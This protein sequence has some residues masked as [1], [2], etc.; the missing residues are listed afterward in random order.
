MDLAS[1]QKHLADV[2]FTRPW[3]GAILYNTL[4]EHRYTNCLELGFAHGVATS[5]MAGA[6]QELGQGKVVAVDLKYALNVTPRADQL[7]HSLGLSK[8]AEFVFEDISHTWYMME[9]IERGDQSFDFC[10]L[11][12]AHTWDVTGFGFLL[13][14]RLLKSGGMIIFDDLNWSFDSSPSM[15]KLPKVMAKSERERTTRQVRKVFD[16]LVKGHPS[17]SKVWETS[18]LGFAIKK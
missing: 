16:L 1:L 2:P 10:F 3:K 7:V 14:E 6:L 4:I 12:D 5:Y 17:F 9:R 18:G 15:S 13:V 11:D 8:Y